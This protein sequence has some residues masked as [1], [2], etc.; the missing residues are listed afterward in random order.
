MIVWFRI[1]LYP[2]FNVLTKGVA[3][4]LRQVLLVGKGPCLYFRS[5]VSF[6]SVS[7]SELS[8]L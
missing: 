7:D 3:R 1:D 4:S 8:I 5:S 6:I 2:K